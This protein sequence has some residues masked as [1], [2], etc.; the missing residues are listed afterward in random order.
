MQDISHH[1][2]F[3]IVESVPVE[4]D[5]GH[6]ETLRTQAAWL[7]MIQSATT[8]IDIGAFYFS[9]EPG[10]ALD[11]ILEAIN[12]AA[13]RGV[14]VRLVLDEA[15]R[16]QSAAT[17]ALL[18]QGEHLVIRYIP[19]GQLTGGVMH[20]KYM[21]V[22]KH[23]CFVGSQNFDWKA[24]DHIHEIG[25]RIKSDAIAHTID[26]VFELDWQLAETKNVTTHQQLLFEP[27]DGLVSSDMP[28][29]F[30]EGEQYFTVHP[31]FSP[32]GLLPM[33]VDW[34]QDE[35]IR[36]LKK[37]RHHVHAQVLQ[38]S[39]DAGFHRK[40]Y[41]AA[42]D[43]A[44][45]EA[46]G[47]GVKI[48]MIMSDWSMA[49]PSVDYVK[50]LAIIPNITIKFST[51]PAYSGGFLEFARVE[52]CKY[53]VIDEDTSWVG[54]GNWEW[55]YFNNTRNIAIIAKHKRIARQLTEIFKKGWDSQYVQ[56]VDP[57]KLYEP[58]K[59]HH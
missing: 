47:R 11:P 42:L 8:S 30:Q 6:P 27:D 4:T 34:E 29:I 18:T 36:L 1:A 57:N 38:Y 40:G 52:H 15:F 7:D 5:Y 28:V 46:A 45:R 25:V 10:E 59:T 26:K 23:D 13:A 50:S 43:N 49:S 53:L 56:L 39:A 2:L 48:E 55:S 22:D 14:N 17:V 12:A 41:W 16:D 24:L 3:E 35:L 37:A 21:I 20:A 19:M 54:T 31:A 51:V 44:L 33:G 9:G 32:Q 58:P